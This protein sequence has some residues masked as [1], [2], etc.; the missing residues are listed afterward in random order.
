MKLNLKNQNNFEALPYKYTLDDLEN[1]EQF[2][3]VAERF[4]TSIGENSDDVFEYLRDADFNLFSGFK[5]MSETKNFTEQQKEDYAYLRRTFDGADMGSLKQYVELVKDAGI[6][7]LRDPTMLASVLLT[8]VTGGTSLAARMTAAT[9]AKVGLKGLAKAAA[10]PS[11]ITAGRSTGYFAAEAGSWTGTDNHFRQQAELN[12]NMRTF[13]SNSELA[14]SIGLG[15]LTGGVFGGLANKNEFFKQRMERLYTNDGYRKDA[16]SDA[17]FK[18]RRFKDR[19]IG[20][21]FFGSA[22]H[23]LKTFAEYSPTARLLGQKFNSEFNKDLTRRSKQRI[24]YSYAEDI[25]FRRGNYKEGY[26]LAIAPLYKTGRMSPELGE[27]VVTLLRGGRVPNASKEV[28]QTAKNLRKFFDSVRQDAVEVGIDVT[29]LKNYFPRS[30]NRD[31]IQ[32]NPDKFKKMLSRLRTDKNGNK[33]RIVEVDKVDDVVDGMLTKQNELYSS[34]SNLLTHGRVFENLDDNLFREFLTNDLH[35]VTTDYW[36]NAARAIEHKKHFL[37]KGKN[38]K[39]IPTEEGNVVLFKQ[40]NEE[41]FI[42]KF[43]DPINKELKRYGSNRQ[44]RAKDKREILNIYKSITGQVDYFTSE[45]GQGIYDF[46]KLANAMAYLPLATVSSLSEA[47]I[48]LGKAPTKS[49]IKGMQDAITNAG[50]IFQRDMGQILK[51]KHQLTDNEI[52]KEMN[53]VFLAVDEAVADLTNRLDGEGLQNETLKRASRG[54][55]RLNMLIPWTKTVQLSAFSTGKDMIMTNLQQLSSGKNLF[56]KKL[57]KNSRTRLEEELFD[58]GVDIKK[59]LKWHKKFGDDININAINDDFYQNDIIRGAGRFTNSVILQTGREFANVPRYMTNPKWDILTQFLRYP[60]VFGNTV[61]RNFARS[62]IKDTTVNAPKL[63]AFVAISTNVAKA[64]NYWRSSE[65][66]RRYID[67]EDDWRTTLKAYQ[68]VGLLGPT[69]YLYRGA[70]GISYGQNPLIAA[71]GTGGPILGDLIGIALYDRGFTETLARKLPLRGTKNIMDRYLGDT[72]EGYFDVREPYTPIEQAARNLDKKMGGGLNVVGRYIAPPL[73]YEQEKIKGLPDYEKGL[74]DYDRE[75]KNIGGQIGRL[76][77]K[78]VPNIFSKVGDDMGGGTSKPIKDIVDKEEEDMLK[79]LYMDDYGNYSPTIKTLVLDAPDDITGPKLSKWLKKQRSAKGIKQKELDYLEVE[80]YIKETPYATGREVGEA[81]S[82]KRLKII[83]NIRKR[84]FDPEDI[85]TEDYTGGIDSPAAN[86]RFLERIEE[87]IK[88]STKVIEYDKIIDTLTEKIN[89]EDMKLYESSEKLIQGRE[90]SFRGT[91]PSFLKEKNRIPNEIYERHDDLYFPNDPLNKEPKIVYDT[92]PFEKIDFTISKTN[93][94]RTDHMYPGQDI[95]GFIFGNSEVG[96][97]YYFPKLEEENIISKSEIEE[98]FNTFTIPFNPTEA[99]IQ[100]KRF[101]EDLN[102]LKKPRETEPILK[103]VIDENSPGGAN[104]RNMIFGVSGP[105]TKQLNYE[106]M[107]YMHFMGRTEAEQKQFGHVVTKD[108]VLMPLSEAVLAKRG[109]PTSNKLTTIHGEEVQSDYITNVYD[110]GLKTE[111]NVKLV[112]EINKEADSLIENLNKKTNI[113]EE[114]VE[115]LVKNRK[116]PAAEIFAKESY[117]KRYST[118]RSPLNYI[119]LDNVGDVEFRD[120]LSE[121]FGY[122]GGRYTESDLKILNKYINKYNKFVENDKNFTSLDK[123]NDIANKRE[124]KTKKINSALLDIVQDRQINF[125]KKLELTSKK[126][127]RSGDNYTDEYIIEEYRKEVGSDVDFPPYY[128]DALDIYVPTSINAPL[129][130]GSNT[131]AHVVPTRIFQ[132]VSQMNSIKKELYEMMAKYGDISKLIPENPIQDKEA[133]KRAVDRVMLQAVKENKQAVSFAKS[134]II[135][136]RYSGMDG[137]YYEYIYDKIVP[138]HLKKLAKEYDIKFAELEIDPY[139]LDESGKFEFFDTYASDTIDDSPY[140]KENLFKVNA[141]IF[142]EKFKDRIIKE[143]VKTFA[144]GGLVT[145]TF[146]VP[147]TKED[148]ADRKDPNTGLPYSDQLDRLGLSQGGPLTPEKLIRFGLSG[149]TP[150]YLSKDLTDPSKI[151]AEQDLK[152][153]DKLFHGAK[154]EDFVTIDSILLPEYNRLSQDPRFKELAAQTTYEQAK[155]NI[156]EILLKTTKEIESTNKNAPRGSNKLGSSAS[157]FYQYLIDSVR[158][159]FNR[160]ERYFTRKEAEKI[161]GKALVNND[162]SVLSQNKQD[163]FFLADMFQRTGTDNFLAPIL[164]MDVTDEDSL[165]K[166]R[167]GA[168][169]LFLKEHHTLSSKEK[170]YNEAT[171]K[172]AKNQWR[173]K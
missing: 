121:S 33:F 28:V 56:G 35:S 111:K 143:G 125:G 120:W 133:I 50:H 73:E 171:I 97:Q 103:E 81:L 101:L 54:F 5:R 71:V 2:Q 91:T 70:E 168:F 40:T 38:V 39:A 83:S 165:D 98:Y 8:P 15:T 161:F 57:T 119:Y 62:T 140:N 46:T 66:Q 9:A 141:L 93:P 156:I 64:T 20:K 107:D 104:Y 129:P 79:A 53:K 108:R 127:E 147:N 90:P 67:E 44:L 11:K 163:V 89:K 110:F 10:K 21:F 25:Q 4:L 136:Q 75:Q 106:D 134:D 151:K 52:V 69:E 19:I 155:E 128:K 132:I 59:G 137:Q 76:L 117:A 13:Y 24:G 153:M 82:P 68:R 164:F 58:L 145:G 23:P 31:A 172:E 34:H 47:F 118:P 96:Y 157:G 18:A 166:A 130:V 148:P 6:D 29:N 86:Q 55:Y 63:A 144:K 154:D 48:T 92:N 152:N 77:S 113:L 17:M 135:K 150:S 170:S 95:E 61:L 142:D 42:K 22:A 131:V 102:F 30:W 37:G 14:K 3:I 65:A 12:T 99:K 173:R 126:N 45:L 146:D 36:M 78:K 51:E 139:D 84:S 124:G 72:I 26:E 85:R 138:K 112:D 122:H 160:V 80:N 27:Q 1:D 115:N 41:Q 109:L 158:P 88:F 43:I 49:A 114:L 162:T 169:E 167:Q 74:P 105:K 100:L 32:Q 123:I 7:F 149:T 159:A 87:D 60:T 16:G 94:M 116:D